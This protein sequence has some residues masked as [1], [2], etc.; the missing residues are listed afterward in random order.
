LVKVMLRICHGGMPTRWIR[1]ATRRVST[2][3]LPDPAAA[4]TSTGP[5]VVLTAWRCGSV[6]SSSNVSISTGAPAAASMACFSVMPT[7]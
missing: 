6:R 4:I 2:R 7:G 5:S 3:V 1:Y